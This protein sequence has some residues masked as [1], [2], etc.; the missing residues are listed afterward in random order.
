MSKCQPF[1]IYLGDKAAELMPLLR[2]EMGRVG[3]PVSGNDVSGSFSLGTPVG[4]LAAEYELRGKSVLVTVTSKP[5]AVSCGKI[6]DKLTDSVLDAKAML[7]NR[8]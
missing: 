4:L 5:A 8:S 1:R 7:R 6:Q 3:A 2:S